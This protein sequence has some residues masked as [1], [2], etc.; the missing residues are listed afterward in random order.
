MNISLETLNTYYDEGWLIK[1]E[2]PTKD[3]TIWNYSRQTQWEDHWDEITL[4]A[5]GL[6]TNSKGEIVCLPFKKFFNWEQLLSVNVKIP[7]G[8]FEV[9][10]K[11]DGQL[12]LLFWYDGEW[13]FT[14][15]GCSK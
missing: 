12:G 5:R 10:E 4:Q 7:D 11:M 1:Q 9:Y 14:S 6:V 8:D 13:I 2:H 3:L 15:R